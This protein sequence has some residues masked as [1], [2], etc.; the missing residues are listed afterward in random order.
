MKTVFADRRQRRHNDQMPAALYPKPKG[1]SGRRK[2]GDQEEDGRGTFERQAPVRGQKHRRAAVTESAAGARIA[3]LLGI[4]GEGEAIQ[5][6]VLGVECSD[7]GGEL[8]IE[9]TSEM[10]LERVR[11]GG[12]GRPNG[13]LSGRG[14]HMRERTERVDDLGCR[15][16]VSLRSA[17]AFR[18][19]QPGRRGGGDETRR[20]QPEQRG[21]E[22]QSCGQRLQRT[23]RAA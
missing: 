20:H 9:G 17:V 22:D 7:Q 16:D 21:R 3:D 15:Q 6:V 2:A 18:W 11:Q 5:D 4:P 14:T 13:D 12:H 10:C 1:N 23:H 19:I 8:D